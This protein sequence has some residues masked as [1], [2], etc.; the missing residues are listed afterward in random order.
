M[1]NTKEPLLYPEQ[2]RMARAALHWTVQHL[3]QKAGL[4]ENTVVAFEAGRSVRESS[5]YR[6]KDACEKAGV[7][8]TQAADGVSVKIA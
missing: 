1:K 2:C 3:A 8:F 5:V 4:A 6:I 7:G